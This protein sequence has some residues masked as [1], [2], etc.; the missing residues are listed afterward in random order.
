[1]KCVFFVGKKIFSHFRVRRF[2][3]MQKVNRFSSGGILCSIVFSP[4]LAERWMGFADELLG[5]REGEVLGAERQ[6]VV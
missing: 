6:S 2:D 5:V 4:E 1:M 3:T